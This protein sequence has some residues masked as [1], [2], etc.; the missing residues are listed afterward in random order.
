MLVSDFRSFNNTCCSLCFHT[1]CF[2][3]ATW[4][5]S[6]GSFITW[7]CFSKHTKSATGHLSTSWTAASSTKHARHTNYLYV[8]LE[9]WLK[10]L[11]CLFERQSRHFWVVSEEC[12]KLVYVSSWGQLSTKFVNI[13]ALPNQIA[14]TVTRCLFWGL[15]AGAWCSRG[16]AQWSGPPDF[17]SPINV[18]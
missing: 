2:T 16:F 15:C 4:W 7:A 9:H 12:R 17:F 10:S 11:I 8:H 18:F 3:A 13:Y 14:Q 1:Q 6:L 5:S